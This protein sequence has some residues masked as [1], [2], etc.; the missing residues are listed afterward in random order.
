MTTAWC[1][2]SA[3]STSLTK[4]KI[5]ENCGKNKMKGNITSKWQARGGVWKSKNVWSLYCFYE[6]LEYTPHSNGY[7]HLI[8]SVCCDSM[9]VTRMYLTGQSDK[10]WKC[11]HRN[12]GRPH[13]H[14]TCVEWGTCKVFL[15]N[16]WPK[17]EWVMLSSH[18]CTATCSRINELPSYTSAPSLYKSLDSPKVKQ[19]RTKS[20]LILSTRGG[21]SRLKFWAH[22]FHQ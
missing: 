4:M 12:K 18:T 14:N 10:D 21:L 9:T 22:L 1:T 5:F 3:G 16:I 8:M 6:T 19:I 20:F 17:I 11:R 7:T 13:G 2:L 15:R